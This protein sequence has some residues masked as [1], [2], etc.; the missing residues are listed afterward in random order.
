[1]TLVIMKSEQFSMLVFV[2]IEGWSSFHFEGGG[3]S[4][5]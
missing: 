4:N 2:N 3:A 5:M 1:M